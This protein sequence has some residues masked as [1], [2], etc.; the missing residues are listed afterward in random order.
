M[1]ENNPALNDP[2]LKGLTDKEKRK[3]L[4][5]RQ[6]EEKLA[7]EDRISHLERMEKEDEEAELND[8]FNAIENFTGPPKKDKVM[9]D[10]KWIW[11]MLIIIGIFV[12]QGV[13]GIFVL[14]NF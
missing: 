1:R 14:V 6:R 9:T 12:I 2:S 8:P 5:K 4:S 3:I 13:I 7:K 10:K 11:P